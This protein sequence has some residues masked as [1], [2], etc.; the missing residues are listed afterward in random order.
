MAH[1]AAARYNGRMSTPQWVLAAASLNDA[2]PEHRA[3]LAREAG[4]DG[5]ELPFEES[6]LVAAADL[7]APDVA[8][9][10]ARPQAVLPPVAGD[11]IEKT[12]PGNCPCL[13]RVWDWRSGGAVASPPTG[14]LN[15]ILA[16]GRAAIDIAAR[17]GVPRIVVEPVRAG[18]TGNATLAAREELLH[19]LRLA[20][21][22][23][24]FD[25]ELAGVSLLCRAGPD[26]L[27]AD[28]DATRDFLDDVCSPWVRGCVDGTGLRRPEE[29]SD[30]CG[31]LG[32]RCGT[33]RLADA[34]SV[35]AAL[36][37]LRVHGCD[38]VLS[39]ECDKGSLAAAAAAGRRRINPAGTA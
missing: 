8:P 5:F 38:P 4:L 30:W 11:H 31:A 22:A 29:W 37:A 10:S 12:E 19:R 7:P 24:R 2:S 28:P 32:A 6:E 20:L 9:D 36:D 33:V 27:L 26:D 23:L 16:I 18:W 3:A 35:D 34:A 14:A 15:R 1:R 25:A 13:A 21:S 39:F 17:K